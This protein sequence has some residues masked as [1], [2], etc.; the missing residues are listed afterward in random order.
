LI[1]KLNLT[2]DEYE[3]TLAI[4]YDMVNPANSEHVIAPC[5]RE[6]RQRTFVDIR[7]K[8]LYVENTTVVHEIQEKIQKFYDLSKNFEDTFSRT[9]PEFIKVSE[10]FQISLQANSENPIY[11]NPNE[12]TSKRRFEEILNSIEAKET[13]ED[14]IKRERTLNPDSTRYFSSSPP[15]YPENIDKSL[16]I[17][18]K[19]A[20]ETIKSDAVNRAN[21]KCMGNDIGVINI[22]TNKN[23]WEMRIDPW[24]RLER[25]SG[26]H[27]ENYYP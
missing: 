17:E 7:D 25:F 9:I 18:A 22:W 27:D 2:E 12:F 5:L 4:L 24:D 23:L 16:V 10:E 8:K 6:L 21:L 13:F 26:P 15:R 11:S 20:I 19:A 3:K 1:T 14:R